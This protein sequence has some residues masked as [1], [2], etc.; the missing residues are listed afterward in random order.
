MRSVAMRRFCAFALL[1]ALVPAFFAHVACSDVPDYP[2][3]MSSCPPDAGWCPPEGLGAAP[4]TASATTGSSSAS[5]SSSSGSPTS[6][7]SGTVRRI[8]SPDFGI[9]TATPY[10]GPAKISFYPMGASQIDATYGSMGFDVKNVAAGKAW[11]VVQDQSM[12]G[13]WPTISGLDVPQPLSV[14]LPLIDQTLVKNIANALPT[15]AAK[16]VSAASAHVV[17]LL[18]HAGAPYKGV[19]VSGGVSGI[20]IAYDTGSGTYSDTATSTGTAGTILLFDTGLS[21]FAMITLT[22]PAVSRSWPV[23][24]LTAPGA[25][26]LASFDLE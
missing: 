26:T 3:L 23:T 5:S 2:M 6:E 11:L 7:L 18:Q 19:H 10:A 14:T 15:V 21:S 25:I 16:G 4:A 13:V 22:D 24:V 9:A 8:V 1:P 20:P 12:A 17:L